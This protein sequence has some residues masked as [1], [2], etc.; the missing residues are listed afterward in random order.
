MNWKKGIFITLL[1]I[2]LIY[3]SLNHL[4]YINSSV[5]CAKFTGQGQTKGAN[6]LLYEFEVNSKK[7]RGNES[8]SK[9][10]DQS[11]DSLEKINCIKVEYSNVTP[12]FNRIIDRQVL[13]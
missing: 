8:S 11:F 5:A 9:I 7:Y 2:F 3:V 4:V 6:Y 10:I 13:K 1:V 12:F